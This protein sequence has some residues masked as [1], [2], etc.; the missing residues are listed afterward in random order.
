MARLVIPDDLPTLFCG[1]PTPGLKRKE[2]GQ[3]TTARAIRIA[4]RRRAHMRSIAAGQ[5]KK[6]AGS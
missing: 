6:R 1:K 3:G 4:A 2:A 5:N